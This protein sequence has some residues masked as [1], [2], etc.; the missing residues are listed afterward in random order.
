MSVR[1]V[2][3]ASVVC[4]HVRMIRRVRITGGKTCMDKTRYTDRLCRACTDKTWCTDR[5]CKACTDY[6]RCTDQRGKIRANDPSCMDQ[7]GQICGN[8]PE[9][10][11]SQWRNIYTD[12][13]HDK[14]LGPKYWNT[15]EYE[16]SNYIVLITFLSSVLEFLYF[17][18]PTAGQHRAG[19]PPPP[20]PP[21]SVL[22][23]LVL[24]ATKIK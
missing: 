5:L 8:D 15:P 19:T 3:Y 14:N 2:G 13:Q 17:P 24:S 18:Q 21:N 20:P 6:L 11:E 10:Y 7:C 22:T 1:F 16:K 4:R 23:I 9:G 12:L